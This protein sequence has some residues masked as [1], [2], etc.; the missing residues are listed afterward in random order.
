MPSLGFRVL[1]D[2]DAD[3]D[4]SIRVQSTRTSGDLEVFHGGGGQVLSPGRTGAADTH[5]FATSGDTPFLWERTVNVAGGGP[6]AVA[7]R[8]FSGSDVSC[9][10][11]TG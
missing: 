5:S 8:Y 6:G 11:I 2:G 1:T 4:G 10:A 9:I 3:T 7:R